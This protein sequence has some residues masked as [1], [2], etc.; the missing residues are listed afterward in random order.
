MNHVSARRFSHAW[1]PLAKTFGLVCVVAGS[2]LA[3]PLPAFPGDE[4]AGKYTTG[5][6]GST[7]APTTVIAV[8]NL[9]DSGAGRLRQAL[10]GTY[11]SRTVVF[12]CAA[13]SIW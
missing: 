4:G 9:N 8:T 2:A 5:G 11:S 10:S 3:Q 1:R 13:P 6:R 7:S 12:R